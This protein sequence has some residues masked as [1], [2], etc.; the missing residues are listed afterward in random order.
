ML[1]CVY[2]TIMIYC[3]YQTLYLTRRGGR[4][5]WRC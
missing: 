4:H 3:W 5:H 2:I 1:C